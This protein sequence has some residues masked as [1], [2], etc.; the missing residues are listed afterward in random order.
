MT[1]PDF[2]TH[3]E[4]II[5]DCRDTLTAK[6]R[7]YAGSADKFA[8]F[9]RVADAAGLDPLQV[10]YIYAAKHWDAV[11]TFVKTRKLASEPIESRF[12]DLLNYVF[13]MSGIVREMTLKGKETK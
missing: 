5:A 10:M 1:I 7:D 12:V 8:N 3:L 9:K 2:D 4:Q 6:G 11:S 13:L